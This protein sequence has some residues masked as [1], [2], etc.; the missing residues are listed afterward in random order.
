MLS[1]VLI[2]GLIMKYAKG[3]L[4]S[5]LLYLRK[6]YNIKEEIFSKDI[7]NDLGLSKSPVSRYLKELVSDKLLIKIRIKPYKGLK[8]P[9]LKYYFTA[10][11]IQIA[12]RVFSLLL[13]EK[14]FNKLNS[15]H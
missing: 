9:R 1:Q 14:E 4:S 6:E 7:I 10:L 2:D 8:S 11:G 15:K 5:F 3:V 13:K 12:N